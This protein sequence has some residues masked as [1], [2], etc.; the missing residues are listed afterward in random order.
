MGGGSGWDYPFT[1]RDESVV[2]DHHGT[3]VA[4]PYRWLEDPDSLETQEWVE[5]QNKL[6]RSYVSQ[7]D[8]RGRMLEKLKTMNEYDKIGCPFRAGDKIF[9]FQ[10]KGS[11]NQ[12]GAKR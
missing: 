12:V 4:D 2:E 5:E 1:R 10:K 11:Q 7:G 8:V 3:K 6:S 9:Y